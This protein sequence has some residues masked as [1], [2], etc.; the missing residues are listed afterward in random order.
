MV[1]GLKGIKI[2]ELGVVPGKCANVGYIGKV[3]NGQSE[4]SLLLVITEKISSSG[5]IQVIAVRG[6]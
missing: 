6:E 4:T 5:P 3:P 2:G 1:F